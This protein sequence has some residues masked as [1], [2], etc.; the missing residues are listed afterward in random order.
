MG[1]NTDSL[2]KGY[3]FADGTLGVNIGATKLR[4]RFAPSPLAEEPDFRDQ[5]TE[6]WPTLRILAS[7]ADLADNTTSEEINA[8]RRI[9]REFKETVPA[10]LRQNITPFQSHQWP[11]LKHA[12]TNSR[13][14]DLLIANPVLAYA[15][16]SSFEFRK[17]LPDVAAK[18]VLYRLKDKQKDILAWLGFN[19]TPA[20]ARLF[21][22]IKTDDI[23]PAILRKLI[24]MPDRSAAVMAALAQL[25]SINSEVIIFLTHTALSTLHTPVL[26]RE[27]SQATTET[28]IC[29]QLINA[30]YIRKQLGL[31]PGITEFHSIQRIT[32]F[33]AEADQLYA[34]RP[35]PVVEQHDAEEPE[36][37][38]PAGQRRLRRPPATPKVTSAT[39]KFPEPP[40]PAY[41]DRFGS[42]TPI[43]D[44]AQL[45]KESLDMHNCVRTFWNDIM[46]G[47]L[48]IYKVEGIDRCTLAIRPIGDQAWIRD[49]IKSTCNRKAKDRAIEFVDL[50]L[51]RHRAGL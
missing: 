34:N 23:I 24:L 30:L 20:M 49:Q 14:M 46:K 50:W 44:Y 17:T 35:V 10:D 11:L 48:F 27:L 4:I 40:L 1:K 36:Q 38:Q 42:I 51:A 16:A 41:S 5:W 29:S 31:E 22:K 39:C 28:N 7:D 43:T 33:C 2:Q 6:A 25:E 8:K 37:D 12:A 15:A 3:S 47:R 18:Q 9:F 45:L 26:L 19:G 21:T 32:E 13:M